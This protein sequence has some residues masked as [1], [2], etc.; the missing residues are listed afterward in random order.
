M[1]D[2]KRLVRKMERLLESLNMEI[3]RTMSSCR[4][5]DD[6]YNEICNTLDEFRHS[7][8]F[9]VDIHG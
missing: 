7:D 6:K 2:K 1:D 8:T 3:E 4:K 9:D 5:L